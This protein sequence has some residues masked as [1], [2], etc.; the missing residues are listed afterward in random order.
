MKYLI[1]KALQHGMAVSK[2][3][4]RHCMKYR[5][6]GAASV[7]T[8]G[9]F[10]YILL[11]EIKVENYYMWYY[12]LYFPKSTTLPVVIE[13]FSFM[14]HYM[15]EGDIIYSSADLREVQVLQ[16]HYQLSLLPP[17]IQYMVQFK[18]G[19]CQSLH[20]SLP[21]RIL[22]QSTNGSPHLR[23]L[24]QRGD[25]EAATPLFFRMNKRIQAAVSEILTCRE[26]NVREQMYLHER[27]LRLQNLY[28][29]D[30]DTYKR[31][32]QT[33]RKP[34]QPDEL[35]AYILAHLEV[36]DN[37]EENPLTLKKLAARSGMT[38]AAFHAAYSQHYKMPLDDLVAKLRIEQAMRLV[39][40]S[41]HSITEIAELVGYREKTNFTRAFKNHFGNPPSFYR[42]EKE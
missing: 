42:K 40:H 13:T 15:L 5:I 14:L 7:Y 22:H 28:M 9:I 18:P 25:A 6:P 27:L 35:E 29:E 10:G 39:K 33:E 36:P 34:L 21:H 11:Q 30:I 38:P 26:E 2:A 32:L 17:D 1:P 4:P 12:I 23:S 31:R 24:L 19:Q 16:G 20:I 41:T 37:K 3:V 8:E